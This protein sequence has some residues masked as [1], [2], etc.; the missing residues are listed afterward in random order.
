MGVIAFG[1]VDGG[2]D[3]IYRDGIELNRLNFFLTDFDLTIG[4]MWF[5]IVGMILSTMSFA[6]D[7]TTA[8]RVLCT[9]LKDVRRMAFMSGGFAIFSGLLP[10]AVG[11]LLFA[12]FRHNPASMNPVMSNDQMVPIFIIS[13][14]P[15]G[16]A[17]LILATMF[18]AAMSTV[19]TSVNVCAVLFCEDIYKKIFKNL[20][21][22]HEM[23]V[24]QVATLVS[25]V[26]GTGIAILLLNMEMP[27]LWES[28]QRIMSYV[29]GG[30]GAVFILGMFTRRTNEFGAIAG[31]VGGFIA[32]YYFNNSE[33]D[34]HYSGLGILIMGSS[35]LFGYLVS[36][37]T[38]GRKIDLKG[39]TIFDQV[40][41][42]RSEASEGKV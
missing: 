1:N 22:K 4:N 13:E 3:T 26:I 29:G 18:A 17:G 24:M 37:V 20:T 30:F 25:G 6:S 11:I 2:W 19:S 38:P 27:T 5:A 9:P 10:A 35:I 16:M 12:Y 31:A 41:E 36:L 23:R 21:P 34:I 28:F 42:I 8:Q 14:V 15:M 40:K 32:A 33:W 7:Q 39:L